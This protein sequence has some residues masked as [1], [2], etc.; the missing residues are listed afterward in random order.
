MQFLV[1]F[2]SHSLIISP[3]I[4]TLLVAHSKGKI[5]LIDDI[6]SRILRIFTCVCIINLCKVRLSKVNE[7][8]N[9]LEEGPAWLESPTEARNRRKHM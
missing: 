5:D 7:C 6:T 1:E 3:R 2:A 8:T 9:G 4:I